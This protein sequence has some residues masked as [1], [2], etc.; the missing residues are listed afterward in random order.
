MARRSAAAQRQGLEWLEDTVGQAIEEFLGNRSVTDG[1]AKV[2]KRA[3]ATK[4]KVDRNVETILHL[5]N[6]P[7]RADYQKLLVKIETLQGSLV[8]LN[9]KLD[10][11]L[12]QQA[13]HSKPASTR[14]AR[15]IR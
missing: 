5:M 12:A 8:N 9:M 11:L 7:S 13:S 4:G 15:P 3:A 6:L 1:I 14:R 10:R 2:A